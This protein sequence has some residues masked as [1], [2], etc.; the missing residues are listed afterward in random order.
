VD[1]AMVS[2]ALFIVD[3]WAEIDPTVKGLFMPGDGSK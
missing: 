3:A 1:I 2:A